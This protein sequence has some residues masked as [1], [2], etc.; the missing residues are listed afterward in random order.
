MGNTDISIYLSPIELPEYKSDNDVA[1]HRMGDF[2]HANTQATGFPDLHKLDIALLGIRED[3]LA[4]RNDG[5]SQGPDVIRKHLYAL[6]QG[7][8]NI[9]IAD[10]GDILPGHEVNDTYF[11]LSSVLT[12]L[13]HRSITP[14]IIGGSQDLTYAQYRAYENLGQIINIVAVDPEFDLGNDEESIDSRS[15]LSHIILHQPNYLFNYTNIG[16]QTYFVDSAAINLMRN[17]YFDIYRLG[18]IRSN[19]EE[20][21][22]LV[23]NADMLTFDISSVRFSDAPGNNNAGPNGFYGEEACQLARYAGLSDKLSSIGFYEYNPS[24]DTRDQ[25]AFLI[26]QMI[27][28]FIDGFCNRK[29]DFPFMSKED[30]LKYIVSVNNSEHDITFYK[31]K[32]SDRWWMNVPCT[33]TQSQLYERHYLVPCSY[34]DYQEA[35]KNE[36]PE[37][38]WQVYQKLLN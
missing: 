5:C 13:L 8:T 35:L 20:A 7:D 11:A 2:I 32:K 19:L 3:R 1:T 25:T 6:F 34:S 26:A 30:Y 10:L 12:E 14:V 9:R 16:Y 29:N 23:R 15:Y 21:E 33:P 28:Y 4:Y 31:S 18:S 37:R 24:L 36:I 38:W 22:P 17:M 27:W